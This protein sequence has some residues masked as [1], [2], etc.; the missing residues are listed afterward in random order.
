MR[1]PC[2]KD[3]AYICCATLPSEGYI[4][5]VFGW[6]LSPLLQEKFPTLAGRSGRESTGTSLDT[7]GKKQL[8]GKNC[9]TL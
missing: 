3:I 7:G 5:W 9:C 4:R 2:Q 8:P 6:K 1:V